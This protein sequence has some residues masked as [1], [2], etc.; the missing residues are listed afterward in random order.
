MRRYCNDEYNSMT[1]SQY[2]SLVD[3]QARMLLKADSS[4]FKLGFLWW[5][6]E[7]LMWVFVF[8]L[9]FNVILDSGKRPGD[10]ILFLGV[11]K[12]AFIW[13]SKTVMHASG[14]IIA[15]QGLVGKIDVPK[16]LFPVSAI[17]E[18]LY[19]Q[20]TVY[21]L[22]FLILMISGIVPSL[23]WLWMIPILTVMYLLILACGLI[24]ACLVS[25]LR[26]FHMLISLGMTF[27]LF[28]SGIFW[29]VR[30][31]GSQEKTDLLLALN[32]L[33]FLIDAHRQVLMY[34]TTPDLLHLIAIGAGS[35]L[36]IGAAILYMRRYSHY[37]ALKVLT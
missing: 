16:S 35:A 22:L 31:L 4:K 37:L 21:L 23:T 33:A 27:L 24:G 11:G 10:F 17:Q 9:V 2:F 36:L 7:P 6:L 8:F 32:P 12:F 28:T 30:A 13:F 34:H 18:S 25:V 20:S 1:L 19:R 3:V 26:D 14:S 15:N 5:F 29:D